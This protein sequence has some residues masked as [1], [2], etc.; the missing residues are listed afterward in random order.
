MKLQDENRLMVYHFFWNSSI[1]NNRIDLPTGEWGRLSCFS[2]LQA[3][4]SIVRRGYSKEIG[5]MSCS[6]NGRCL[7]YAL[8]EEENVVLRVR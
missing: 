5:W 7:V 4:L 8:F 3:S 2:W 6:R 1:V